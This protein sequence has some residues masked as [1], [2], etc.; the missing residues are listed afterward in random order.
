M[1]AEPGFGPGP[2]VDCGAE[3]LGEKALVAPGVVPDQ[4]TETTGR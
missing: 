4:R 3:Q 1:G 2:A